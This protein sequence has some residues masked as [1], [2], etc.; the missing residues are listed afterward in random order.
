MSLTQID[1]EGN[2]HEVLTLSEWEAKR[3]K[4]AESV[5]DLGGFLNQTTATLFE[6]GKDPEETYG[7]IQQTLFKTAVTRGLIDPPSEE[8]LQ[9]SFENFS[10][11][12]SEDP[13]RDYS[14]VA[15]SIAQV[16]PEAANTLQGYY[17]QVSEARKTKQ[18]LAIPADEQTKLDELKAT[19]VTPGTI[20]DARIQTAKE[21]GLAF[22]DYPVDDQ[23]QRAVWINPDPAVAKD[24]AS[25]LDSFKR[26]NNLISAA[27]LKYAQKQVEINPGRAT[28]PWQDQQNAELREHLLESKKF[29]SS[30]N[31]ALADIASQLEN[32]L[33]TAREYQQEAY[34]QRGFSDTAEKALTTEVTEQVTAGYAPFQSGFGGA[35]IYKQE[36]TGK[37]AEAEIS[38]VYDNLKKA[39]PTNALFSQYTRDQFINAAGDLVKQGL[40][41]PI[42][43]DDPTKNFVKLSDG[44]YTPLSSTA[45]LPKESFQAAMDKLGMDDRAK[46]AAEI[47]RKGYLANNVDSIDE[48]LTEFDGEKYTKFAL[49]WTAKQDPRTSP[50]KAQLL[51]DYMAEASKRTDWNV[52][53]T[54]ATGI[55]VSVVKSFN[56]IIQAIGGGVSNLI[57]FDAGKETFTNWAIADATTE[58]NRKK[59]TNLYGSDLGLGYEFLSQAAPMV[60]DIALT[61][62]ASSLTKGVVKGLAREAAVAGAEQAAKTGVKGLLAREISIPIGGLIPSSVQD[63]AG[64]VT[65]NWI[66]KSLSPETRTLFG[67]SY[68]RTFAN[69]GEE[70]VKADSALVAKV[71]QGVKADLANKLPQVVGTA[72]QR[73]ASFARSAES[74]YVDTTLNMRA[75]LNPD[76]SRK[77][78][79]DQVHQAA[80]THSLVS[81]SI[82][83]LVEHGFGKVF[84][85]GADAVTYGHANLKQLKYYTNRVSGALERSS[86]GGEEV[87]G[88]LKAVTREIVKESGYHTVKEGVGEFGEEFTDQLAQSVANAMLDNKDLDVISALK[89]SFQA[90][91]LGF[92]Y[93]AGVHGATTSG[94]FSK[95]NIQRDYAQGVAQSVE[96]RVL[97]GV[98]TKLEA[99][100]Q[101]PETVAV[102]KN[103]LQLASRKAQPVSERLPAR[104]ASADVVAALDEVQ[105]Q[106]LDIGQRPSLQGPSGSTPTRLASK[107][108]ET[109]NVSHEEL[110]IIQGSG[111]KSTITPNDVQAYVDQRAASL[112]RSSDIDWNDQAA[113]EAYVKRNGVQFVS[114]GVPE[115]P[116]VEAPSVEETRTFKDLANRLVVVD[117]V[118]GRIRIESD[119]VLLDP[120]TGEAP[121]IVTPN[122]DMLATEFEGF[123]GAVAEPSEVSPKRA[124]RKVKITMSDSGQIVY[125][126]TKYDAPA[127]PVLANVKLAADG[128]IDSMFV[129][130]QNQNGKPT[131]AYVT[132]ANAQR[133]QQVYES[134]GTESAQ[135]FKDALAGSQ[136]QEIQRNQAAANNKQ[137]RSSKRRQQKRAKNNGPLVTNRG[138][139]VAEQEANYA[140]ARIHDG[141]LNEAL[142]SELRAVS[143]QLGIDP[144]SFASVSEMFSVLAPELAAGLDLDNFSAAQIVQAAKNVREGNVSTLL[145]Y[146]VLQE[147]KTLSERASEAQWFNKLRASHRNQYSK[148]GI[149]EGP[150][151]VRAV[152]QSIA[153]SASNKLHRET[154]SFLLSLNTELCPVSVYTA[155]NDLGRSGMYL[156][157]SNLILINAASDNGGGVVDVLLHELMHFGTENLASNPKND[158]ERDV[159]ARLLALRSE[160]QSKIEAKFGDAI[161]ETL[162]Y[163]VEG[164]M[165]AHEEFNEDT[166]IREFIVHYYASQNF[167]EQLA[168]LSGKGERGFVQ[169]FMDIIASW[170]S[171]KRVPDPDIQNLV[172]TMLDLK[173]AVAEGSGLPG[174]GLGAILASRAEAARN[175]GHGPLFGVPNPFAREDINWVAHQT[176]SMQDGIYSEEQVRDLITNGKFGFLTAENPDKST[177][178][179]EVNAGFNAR[180]EQWL[181][182]RGYD[183]IDRVVGRYVNGENSFLVEG[184]TDQDAVDFAS[185]FQQDSVAT[186]SGLYYPDGSYEARD[187]ENLDS[188][189]DVQTDDNFFTNIRTKDGKQ[190]TV[191]VSYPGVKQDSGLRPSKDATPAVISENPI[192]RQVQSQKEF[193]VVVSKDTLQP[194]TLDGNTLL[195]NEQLV[196]EAYGAYGPEEQASLVERDLALAIA[197]ELAIQ[198][199]G[200]DTYV[201]F[202]DAGLSTA[203]I[204]DRTA[205]NDLT[206]A[207]LED[208]LVLGKP[209]QDLVASAFEQVGLRNNGENERLAVAQNRL[210]DLYRYLQRGGSDIPEQAQAFSD[211]ISPEDLAIV[212]R[213]KPVTETAYY[214]RAYAGIKPEDIKP[215]QALGTRNP[216]G[217]TA[218]ERGTDPASLVGLDVL[219]RDPK[220]YR[221]NALYL[222]EYPIVAREFPKLAAKVRGLR[223]KHQKTAVLIRTNADEIKR[224]KK[225]LKGLLAGDKRS[226]SDKVLEDALVQENGG[227]TGKAGR[228]FATQ[229]AALE[230]RLLKS[231]E[232]KARSTKEKADITKTLASWASDPKH[233]ISKL[234]PQIY[235]TVIDN[236]QSNLMALVNLFPENIRPIAKL[237]YDGANKIANEFS[238]TYAQDIEQAAGVLAVFSPQKD[239]FMNIGL[240]ERTLKIWHEQVILGNPNNIVWGPEMTAQWLKRGGEPQITTEAKDGSKPIYENGKVKAVYDDEGNQLEDEQGNPLFEGWS[241]ANAEAGRTKARE[242]LKSLQGQ[243]LKDLSLEDQARF[244]RMYSEVNDPSAFMKYAPDGT[245][246]Q[247]TS[248]SETS[249]KELKIAWGAY[250]TIQKAIRI[251]RS[252]KASKLDVVSAELGNQHKVRSFYNNIVDPNNRDGHVTMDTHAV[253]ALYW[254]ALS[255]NSFEVSQNFGLSNVT[256]NSILGVNG[257]YPANAEAYRN[258]AEAF[259]LLPREIQSITWEAVRL[260]FPAKWKSN[261]KN[262]DAVRNVWAKY[263]ADKSFTIEDARAEIFRL[264]TGKDI[265]EAFANTEHLIKGLG[266][267]SW[268]Q[269]ELRKGTAGEIP[270]KQVQ[271]SHSAGPQSK[272]SVRHSE[273]EAKFNAGT[274]T[275]EETKEAERLV[276]VQARE[277]DNIGPVYHGTISNFTE[278]KKGDIGFH[279]GT[280]PQA[281]SRIL[282]N[283]GKGKKLK[284]GKIV[285][286]FVDIKKPLRLKDEG[287]WGDGEILNQLEDAGI[288]TEDNY[289]ARFGFDNDI[290]TTYKN[291]QTVIKEAGYDSIVYLNRYEETSNKVADNALREA[292][293]YASD[294]EFKSR[295]PA[296][297]SYIVFNPSQIKSAAPFTGIPLDER[298]NEA[299]PDIRYSRSAAPKLYREMSIENALELS[300]N[301][302]SDSPFGTPEFYFSTDPSLALGQG[303]NKGVLIEFDSSFDVVAPRVSKPGSIFVESSGGGAERIGKIQPSEL[304][305]HITAITVKKDAKGPYGYTFALKKWV[306]SLET[307]GWTRSENS[308][309]DITIQKPEQYVAPEVRL[310]R[311]AAPAIFRG[312]EVQLTH[313]SFNASLKETDPKMHGTGGIGVEKSRQQAYKEI[314]QPRTYFG[315][316]SYTREQVVGPHRYQIKVA[317][318]SLYD[319]EVDPLSL[320]PTR[321]ERKAAGYALFDDVA[322]RTMY[323]KAIKDQGFAGYVSKSFSAGVLFGKHK[324]TKIADS[325]RSLVLNPKPSQPKPLLSRAVRAVTS[326]DIES[327]YRVSLDDLM[328]NEVTGEFN[329]GN[330]FTRLFRASGNLDPRMFEAKQYQERAMALA[331]QRLIG[332]KDTFMNALKSEPLTDLDDVNDALGS[333]APT[334]SA[335]D[336]NA[337]VAKRDQ[338]IADARTNYEETDK[339]YSNYKKATAQ[340]RAD[341]LAHKDPKRYQQEVSQLQALLANSIEKQTR[342]AAIVAAHAAYDAD[343]QAARA[344]GTKAVL[345]TQQQALLRLERNS[346]KVAFAVTD[347]RSAIDSLSQQLVESFGP[348]DPLRAVITQNLGVY[349]TRSYAIHHDEGYA[350][351]IKTD[352]AFAQTRQAARDYFEKAWVDRTY[353]AW[354][355]NDLYAIYS[356]QEVRALVVAEAKAK[357]I[358]S[359]ELDS[360][361]EAHGETPEVPGRVL[362]KL[363]LSRFMEKGEVPQ[364]LRAIL[365]EI[366]NP[367]ENALRTYSNV[368]N[369]LGTQRLLNDF[370]RI[371][372]ANGWL[373]TAED[374]AKEPE[375]YR[376]YEPLVNSTKTSGGNPLSN[377]YAPPE[378]KEAFKLT[379]APE[380]KAKQGDAI[381][382]MKKVDVV[383]ARVVGTALGTLTLGSAGFYVRNLT[384]N[385]AYMAANGF[386]ATPE[387]LADSIQG[388]NEIY[389]TNF[390][391]RAL[392]KLPANLRPD[393]KVSFS[394]LGPLGADLI[395]LGLKDTTSVGVLRD[396]FGGL[397]G[398]PMGTISELEQFVRNQ[399]K[400]ASATVGVAKTTVGVL[401]GTVRTLAN[402]A[403]SLDLLYKFAYYSHMVQVYTEANA[404]EKT[405]WTETQIKQMAARTVR[406]TTQ[407]NSEQPAISKAFAKSELGVLFNS[408][409]RFSVETVRLPFATSSVAWQEFTSGNPVLRKRGI[410]RF[411]G[412]GAVLAL[413]GVSELVKWIGGFDDE[414]EQAVRNALPPWAKNVNYYFTK[415]SKDPTKIKAWNLT[416]VHPFSL[417]TDPFIR[418]FH[419]IGN[420]RA[421]ET[422]AVLGEAVANTFFS[423]QIAV[424][425]FIQLRNNT[426]T[427]GGNIWYENDSASTAAFKGLKYLANSAYRLRTV[428][429]FAEA[430]E[431]YTNN[432]IYDHDARLATAAELVAEEFSPFQTKKYDLVKLSRQAFS[433]IKRDQDAVTAERG[434]LK[435]AS[436]LSSEDVEEVYSS[437][438]DARLF[439]ARKLAK[440]VA[441]F[442][443]LGVS[444]QELARQAND[445]GISRDRFAQVVNRGVVDRI[446]F[447]Q[448]LFQELKQI[449]GP[450]NGEARVQ[451]LKDSINKRPSRLPLNSEGE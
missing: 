255:G 36:G 443:K 149:K 398:N 206:Q 291:L 99:D 198:K 72:T 185:E 153:R 371:G 129:L 176:D 148:H 63:F 373:V 293:I 363:D 426:D 193:A 389:G 230:K 203:Q 348:T 243:A 67:Q 270:L 195:V 313:W 289:Y 369:F 404:H 423:P 96:G 378:V 259:G 51:E 30:K 265:N 168:G 48:A 107:L 376:N 410:Q 365:G 59:Y 357:S 237:W 180:A 11:R 397:N 98:I 294:Q 123:E 229:Q 221:T 34:A 380:H 400:A 353:K 352:P 53:T 220:A 298:F 92:G 434:K 194:F 13:L 14:L 366:Q 325:D 284:G 425:A 120:E 104:P 25:I 179:E 282:E 115:A 324:V 359:I 233:E 157:E 29:L 433:K 156:P 250:G 103:R 412:L 65:K 435:S 182:D 299:L 39:Y 64:N 340:A 19:Y 444:K 86:L 281:N 68:V 24:S 62:G 235:Q 215:G 449:G 117:G 113:V 114:E 42:N 158:F 301:T 446:V 10:K 262:V 360:F 242:T 368:S 251:M 370:T 8:T 125:G 97:G 52:F 440:T 87:L 201:D 1:P 131:Y 188:P 12:L 17:D 28:A 252:D 224:F 232:L 210:G 101:S 90:G 171:G 146:L 374:K 55:G 238:S 253:A 451:Y 160:I 321:E 57:G 75:E 15:N 81:G 43:N 343:I 73:A 164:R 309:G 417:I 290:D 21:N 172:E 306:K 393:E 100:G 287:A 319:Y 141:V 240:A 35:P 331:N 202:E 249:G 186:D 405:K 118:R 165:A 272:E 386:V 296:E 137:K 304:K 136:V 145:D 144:D 74:Q 196:D 16:D 399:G 167:R 58:A 222:T 3:G 133:L 126:R 228:T 31:P 312:R 267:P 278:F 218:T 322:A 245:N 143:T 254:Q 382:L 7:K 119:G 147:S 345:V 187:G 413:S 266:F 219:A 169:R 372:T 89:D 116:S 292:R 387:N 162:R 40:E 318:D 70:A 307:A 37:V 392:Q 106:P 431:A 341:Y 277:A 300:P 285:E 303:T 20:R 80:L 337:A 216:T 411:A 315:Y 6:A 288:I 248:R 239:W 204:I 394:E 424:D 214:S 184:F 94:V 109:L 328:V 390:W 438:E 49:E 241:S 121:Y 154:A 442:E 342:D 381:E 330:K 130:V 358:G 263:E 420:K 200:F 323:E 339:A 264:A 27:T 244:I 9:K 310:S 274:I 395:A 23:G 83:A 269:V 82:T 447:P 236:T 409:L 367:I 209:A 418:S 18:D 335:A 362:N 257:L 5:E 177:V 334:V 213:L 268:A 93:G 128:S 437:L 178:D 406:R 190:L 430:F 329:F 333:T 407:G 132:G 261:K 320:Y 276:E 199:V 305:K 208:L 379:F 436:P 286:L 350:E 364:E 33:N 246:T 189:Y 396:L 414:E 46:A 105:E 385:V 166:A 44:T 163:A 108:A 79:D 346:P 295:Y 354:R 85:E 26:S 283:E 183:K 45:L 225:S 41:V 415:D 127:K 383:L 416:Y 4:P 327:A 375:R 258:A 88:A 69:V 347:F 102:L 50:S 161:P 159:R 441:G 260:L 227:L 297:D 71:F 326:P 308:K 84:G 138:Q 432:S 275:P 155:P 56:P 175:A 134:R 110:H 450:A 91:L 223:N 38:K 271:Y 316:S 234:A 60:A 151:D 427:R 231:A 66:A 403:E 351:K 344:K 191:R 349:L 448:E 332:L 226:V 174:Q 401:A 419:L 95:Q 212:E 247:E 311:S 377:F 112:A 207:D 124:Q 336:R 355:A 111:K 140:L 302:F 391:N 2:P 142:V 150:M 314:Y 211:S 152:L 273:L 32:G 338:A 22:V 205:K 422:P 170:F 279:V 388:L 173:K 280:K 429:K 428:S 445:V 181:K 421:D 408:F 384:S 77:F 356:D 317:G 61:G 197:H 54:K 76:G 361:I 402:V 139:Q 78:T 135:A 192:T 217:T 122:P 256:N 439:A 47:T